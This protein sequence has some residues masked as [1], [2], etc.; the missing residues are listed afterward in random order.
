MGNDPCRPGRAGINI[1][2]AYG[3]DSGDQGVLH[4]L[5]E[6][7][8]GARRALMY[9]NFV[10]QAER[11]VVIAPVENRLDRTATPKRCLR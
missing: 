7:A 5:V 8:E 11:P 4:I 10:I 2:G 6:D 1:D 9:A 3:Y